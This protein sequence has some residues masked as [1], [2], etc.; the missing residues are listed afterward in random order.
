ML[1]TSFLVMF[2]SEYAGNSYTTSTKKLRYG[3]YQ[4][5]QIWIYLNVSITYDYLNIVKFYVSVMILKC[6]RHFAFNRVR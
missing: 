4:L 3:S 1:A 5:R 6:V 2:A